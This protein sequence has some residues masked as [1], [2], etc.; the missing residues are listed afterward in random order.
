MIL[1]VV[2]DGQAG[3]QL[4]RQGSRRDDLVDGLI[5]KGGGAGAP[6][7]D[8]SR[9]GEPGDRADADDRVI[10]VHVAVAVVEDTEGSATAE[11]SGDG[12]G[13]AGIVKRKVAEPGLRDAGDAG[14]VGETTRQSDRQ[15]G[16]VYV[17]L[18]CVAWGR[19]QPADGEGDVGADVV[20]GERRGAAE[21]DRVVESTAGVIE[22]QPRP[23]GHRQRAGADGASDLG[24]AGSGADAASCGTDDQPSCV[25]GQSAGEVAGGRRKL[26]QAVAGL[27]DRGSCPADERRNV[28]G[29]VEVR[30]SR[31]ADGDRGHGEGVGA[32]SQ[33]ERA[34]GDAR[35]SGGVTRSRDDRAAARER[36]GA[37]HGQRRSARAAVTVKD[38]AVQGL[39]DPC[40]KRQGG[41]SSHREDRAGRDSVTRAEVDRRAA[42]GHAAID[43]ESAGRD[44]HITRRGRADIGRAAVD[45]R[46]EGVGVGSGQ[47]QSAGAVLD[48]TGGPLDDRVDR[49][50]VL[51]V[52]RDEFAAA[53][54]QDATD[55][56][57]TNGGV[58]GFIAP[59]QATELEVEDVPGVGERD[60]VGEGAGQTQDR[61]MSRSGWQGGRRVR[62]DG[63]LP[64]HP[65]SGRAVVADET[66]LPHDTDAQAG[67]IGGI[68][69][70]VGDSPGSDHAA[71]RGRDRR[72][73]DDTRVITLLAE[74]RPREIDRGVILTRE[75]GE[76][77]VD[78]SHRA[79]ARGGR[80]DVGALGEGQRA[81]G[82]GGRSRQASGVV[83]GAA[84][85]CDRD[86]VAYAIVVLC[87][88]AAVIAQRQRGVID[89]DRRGVQERRVVFKRRSAAEQIRGPGIRLS[90][91]KFQFR[92]T[93]RLDEIQP[94]P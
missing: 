22:E 17:H 63:N 92:I 32:R 28:E 84:A 34:A 46:T 78:G 79:A 3:A 51:T 41:G 14:R 82:L 6:Y 43:E 88:E 58:E 39:A 37:G 50:R 70:L 21:D 94:R 65:W 24:R 53:A 5:P 85:Q 44:H 2:G 64:K 1:V 72:G 42:A 19:D 38:D 45:D 67:A 81:E 23:G 54:G 56:R 20:V 12:V 76:G 74:V 30:V 52:I 4:V 7:E 29:G 40:G 77:E 71:V 80:E 69:A 61:R 66:A 33:G 87:L 25:H 11:R 59:E 10:G 18:Q 31:P 90:L 91:L 9:A 16:V 89:I 62:R 8:R 26:E 68:I 86:G 73:E 60:V 47:R 93:A 15:E 49:E 35:S 75:T 48:Q 36:E 57:R 83:D 55:S 13:N 27:G